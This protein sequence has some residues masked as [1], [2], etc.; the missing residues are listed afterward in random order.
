MLIY[1]RHGETKLNGTGDGERLRGWLPVPLT[2]KGVRQAHAAG[3][4]L[5]L[6]PDT[7]HTSDLPRALQTANIVG[8]HL[9]MTPHVNTNIRDWNTGSLA[10]TSVK[11]ALPQLQHLIDHPDEPAP[12]GEPFQTYLNRFVPAMKALVASPGV[13]LVVG[14]ARGGAILDGIA[15]PVGGVG[16]QTD[17]AMVKEKP[18]VQPGGAMLINPQWQVKV[19]NP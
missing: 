9:G 10:G 7:F 6:K 11:E 13:H 8:S 15:S 2:P 18:R 19:K 16:D 12:G 5:G 17:P 4:S 3:K 1:L 14:H